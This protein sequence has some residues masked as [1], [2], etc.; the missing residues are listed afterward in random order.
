MTIID[1]MMQKFLCP[2]GVIGVMK[3]GSISTDNFPSKIG[4]YYPFEDAV[5]CIQDP[6]KF[7][8]IFRK[9]MA[10]DK[11]T[12]GHYEGVNV[13]GLEI[14]ETGVR[15][16]LDLPDDEYHDELTFAEFAP[17]LEA[18]EKAWAAA[19]AYKATLPKS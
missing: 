10:G 19:Q 6:T 15:A 17:I 8:P 3:D 11:S 14:T 9:A 1:N 7:A 5:H 16:E 18:W 4:K 12:V 13:A 2:D